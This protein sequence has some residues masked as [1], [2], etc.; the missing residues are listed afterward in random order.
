M[1]STDTARTEWRGGSREQVLW[2]FVKMD[3]KGLTRE[4][5]RAA[6]TV[7]EC[8]VGREKVPLSRI[9]RVLWNE[10]F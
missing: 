10:S 1:H 4:F 3:L 7:S 5:Q 9:C 8:S 6:R 2:S